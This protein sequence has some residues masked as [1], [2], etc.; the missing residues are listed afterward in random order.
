MAARGFT[1]CRVL[2]LPGK[3][4]GE[5]EAKAGAGITF[6]AYI[7]TYFAIGRLLKP[8]IHTIS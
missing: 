6:V 1:C 2:T 5:I 4:I 8:Y 3:T 7:E